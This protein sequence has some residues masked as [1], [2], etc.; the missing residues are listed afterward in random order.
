MIHDDVYWIYLYIDR[1][2]PPLY[3]T[4]RTVRLSVSYL[5]LLVLALLCLNLVSV[6]LSQSVLLVRVRVSNHPQRAPES[7]L[8]AVGKVQT[9]RATVAGLRIANAGLRG[10]VNGLKHG[11]RAPRR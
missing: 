9:S 5:P 6:S 10:V 7:G 2:I 1:T 3:Y 8:A 11:S 4:P